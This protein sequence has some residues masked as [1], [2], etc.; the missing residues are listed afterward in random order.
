MLK[1]FKLRVNK[2][3]HIEKMLLFGSR[4]VGKTCDWSDIDLIIVSDR[5]KNLKFRR[6]S[7]KMYDY[8]DSD[9]PV[10]FLCYTIKEFNIQKKQIG[11]VGEAVKDGV[12]I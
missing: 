3:M 2:E 7:T 10:D 6:R 4:A 12:E 8:W 11:I 9:Y 1:K 5:F